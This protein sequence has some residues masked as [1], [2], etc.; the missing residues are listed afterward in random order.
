MDVSF[1]VRCIECSEGSAIITQMLKE[2]RHA[3]SR[4]VP[5]LCVGDTTPSSSL[6]LL[7][8]S[9]LVEFLPAINRVMG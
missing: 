4:I 8:S 9:L 2:Q 5:S 6:L 7:N 3:V 1:S